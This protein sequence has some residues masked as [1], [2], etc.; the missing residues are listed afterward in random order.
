MGNMGEHPYLQDLLAMVINHL[1]TGM[2]LQEQS[3]VAY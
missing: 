3:L 1:L 2:L